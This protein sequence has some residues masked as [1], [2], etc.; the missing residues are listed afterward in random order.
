MTTEMGTATIQTILPVGGTWNPIE[1][2]ETGGL[3]RRTFPD[4]RDARRALAEASRGILSRCSDP[5]GVKKAD[6]GLAIGYVQS[7][8]TLSFTTVAALAKDN[9]YAMVVLVGGTSLYLLSQTEGRLVKDL[10]LNK[11]RTWLHV[12]GPRG[13]GNASAKQARISADVQTIQSALDEWD[14]DDCDPEERR[15]V[16]ITVMKH[17]G[18]LSTLAEM[19]GRLRIPNSPVLIIDDEADQASLDGNAGS[20]D[21][22]SPTATYSAIDGLRSS[23]AKK[24]SH[25]FLQYT[26]TPQA[27]L[28]IDISDALSPSFVRIL[29][30]GSAYVGGRELFLERE[31]DHLRSIPANEVDN[32]LSADAGPP[33][34]LRDAL[35]SFL[36]GIAADYESGFA[37]E[38]GANRS[39]L[40]HPSRLTGDHARLREWIERMKSDWLDLL[41]DD[42]KIST[43]EERNALNDVLWKAY[44]D[45][46]R[47]DSALPPIEALIPHMRLALRRTEVLELNKGAPP[48]P[49]ARHFSFILIGGQAIERGFT[50]EGLTTT[51]LA[52][53]RGQGLADAIQQR[54]RF[55]GYKRGYLGRVRIWIDD[56]TREDFKNYAR[57]E[58]DL[59][60]RLEPIARN[61]QPLRV[62]RREFLLD[63]QL[64]AT[65]RNV[66][67]RAVKQRR[68]SDEWLTLD[69]PSLSGGDLTD[70]QTLLKTI[71]AITSFQED[72]GHPD[73]TVEQRHLVSD[74]VD[75]SDFLALLADIRVS[76]SD[77]RDLLYG[78]M[79]QIDAYAE[80]FGADRPARIYQMGKGNPRE[81]KIAAGKIAQLYQGRNPRTGMPVYPGDREIMVRN[82]PTLQVHVLE[83]K[84]GIYRQIPAF[85]V[86]MP[87]KYSVGTLVQSDGS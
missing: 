52:R 42:A 66:L 2:E 21:A 72:S 37:K 47:T 40:V 84:D 46:M 11:K 3:L 16:V 28:L 33:V 8:K 53:S 82:E 41:Q 74:P 35:A 70:N 81:R 51:H 57:H 49:W 15:T 85:A 45:L 71:C 38:S 50:V 7:G 34:S 4:D 56:A 73:R 65:R 61:G 14:D 59:R 83:T 86:W 9:N 77:Q 48:V 87:E 79:L 69:R 20:K 24:S 60:G 23:V 80:K 25:T 22:T 44:T 75:L 55:F 18:N 43:P 26:A 54:A 58:L 12:L 5:N 30:P 32:A 68:L 64:R 31:Q 10:E 63:P 39:M 78:A 62:W 67:S 1:G 76:N 29:E 6:A 17:A 27:N 13:G 36:I 19:I